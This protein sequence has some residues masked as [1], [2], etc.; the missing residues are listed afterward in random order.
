MSIRDNAIWRRVGENLES[1]LIATAGYGG[2]T[3]AKRGDMLYCDS[4]WTKASCGCKPTKKL[5]RKG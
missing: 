3:A 1:V 5:L 4:G 2:E